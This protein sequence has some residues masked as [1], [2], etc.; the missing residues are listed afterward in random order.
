[1]TDRRLNFG[2]CYRFE[3]CAATDICDAGELT[4]SGRG[5]GGRAIAADSV[6][7]GKGGVGITAPGV[8]SSLGIHRHIL[9]RSLS[10]DL[11]I[12]EVCGLMR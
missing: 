2:Y 10:G 12:V 3:L 7:G 1:M 6:D 11:G 8:V 4:R 9:R 5:D